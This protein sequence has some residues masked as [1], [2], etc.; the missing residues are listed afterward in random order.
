LARR[1][2]VMCTKTS[3]TGKP[4]SRLGS[5]RRK[6]I[7][8][9]VRQATEDFGDVV[10]GEDPFVALQKLQAV[11]VVIL[12]HAL[13]RVGAG[14]QLAAKIQGQAGPGNVLGAQG[15]Y[16][17]QVELAKLVAIDGQV[18]G[19]GLGHPFSHSSGQGLEVIGTTAV[20]RK[21]E[22]DVG[23]V[24]LKVAG[25]LAA[26]KIQHTAG[27]FFLEAPQQRDGNH[28]IAHLAGGK[29]RQV[30]MFPQRLVGKPLH[31]AGIPRKISTPLEV[32]RVVQT[33]HFC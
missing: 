24:E 29:H 5:S 2:V 9:H 10:A 21:A 13:Y 16:R 12:E 22:V 33:E 6:K 18:V 17:H 20:E 14:V 27:V 30:G 1:V 31:K 15:R 19:A 26:K 4:G 23:A 28:K 8:L 3:G 32:V 11:P 25:N 7:R